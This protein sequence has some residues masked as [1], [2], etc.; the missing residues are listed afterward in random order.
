MSEAKW[1]EVEQR[2]SVVMRGVG[3]AEGCDAMD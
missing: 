3:K 2:R 1:S